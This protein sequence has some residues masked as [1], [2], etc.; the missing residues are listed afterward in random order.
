MELRN[1]VA[2]CG[3][4]YTLQN[5]FDNGYIATGRTNSWQ[6]PMMQAAMVV[7]KLSWVLYLK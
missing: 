1:T 3:P 6:V 7:E 5:N 4:N 2:G